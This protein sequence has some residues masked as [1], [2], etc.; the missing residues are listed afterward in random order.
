M[1]DVIEPS[2]PI[3]EINATRLDGSQEQLMIYRGEVMLVANVASQC[4]RTPQY[5]DLQDLYARYSSRGFTVL[6]FPCNQFGDEEP[7]SS[8][9]ISD[10][11]R[12]SYGVTFPMFSKV[13]VNGPGRHPL[14]EQLAVAAYDDGPAADI[15]WNFEKFL[16]DR[17]GSVARRFRYTMVPSD[18]T[19][20]DALEGL[21]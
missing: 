10:F 3:Y 4:G 20:V 11:C 5:A 14:Y 17:N 21:L 7:G 12:M 18:P 16:I 19:I 8:D 6:G 13:E 9:E 1:S 2:A 15:E